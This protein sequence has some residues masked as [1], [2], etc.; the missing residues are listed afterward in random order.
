MIRLF[1]LFTFLL[2]Q[3]LSLAQTGSTPLSELIK[4]AEAG[5]ANAQFQLGLAFEDGKDVDQDDKAAVDWYRKSAAQGFAKAENSLGVMY[6]RGHGVPRDKEQAFSWYR[7]AAAQALPEADFNV[8][9]SY[10]NGDGVGSDLN[11]AY[12]WMLI[13][14][15]H[16][17]PNAEQALSHISQ[18]LTGHTDYG[19][20]MLGELYEKGIETP[21][22]LKA[23][24]ETYLDL[25]NSGRKQNGAAEIKLCE[26]YGNGTGVAQDLV[27]SK[28]WCRAA[29]KS[30][31]SSAFLMLGRMAENGLGGPKSVKEAEV[32][33]RDAALSM[34]A[35]GFMSMGRLKL[36]S[37]SHDDEKD[38]YYWFFLASLYKVRGAQDEAEK[39]AA[40]LNNSEISKERKKAAEWMLPK[41]GPREQP[42]FP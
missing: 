2:F 9:T 7:K 19:S 40:N 15:R 28:S 41:R 18:D 38:A 30:G 21:K 11:R 8:A 10:Y 22:D 36:Q 39:V 16:G 34:L 3:A 24:F 1:A 27:Q 14:K 33:Y 17:S 4:K 25:A 23:A 26:F 35:D 32:W 5:D 6:S 13:A 29:A 37:G 20:F 12:A 31:I 42:T